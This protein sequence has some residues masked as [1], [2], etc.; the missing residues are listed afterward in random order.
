MTRKHY[1][2]DHEWLTKRI[3]DEIDVSLGAPIGTMIAHAIA[4]DID[5]SASLGEPH[6]YPIITAA[7]ESWLI[8]RVDH[9]LRSEKVRIPVSWNGAT[10]LASVP[11][12]L[13]HFQEHVLPDGTVGMVAQYHLWVH[14]PWAV[15][16]QLRNRKVTTRDGAAKQVLALDRA[17]A[18]RTRYPNL[19][20][21][22]AAIQAGLDP[23]TFKAII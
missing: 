16:E 23:L 10:E 9:Q 19:T 20:P 2:Y 11:S 1:D 8:Q 17:L 5:L 7:L 6:A 18:L 14:E 12:R 22:E 15:V 4:V 21:Y 13:A 3:Q